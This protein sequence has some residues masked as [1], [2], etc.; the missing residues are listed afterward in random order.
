MQLDL[1]RKLY[2]LVALF[3]IVSA[4]Y[5]LTGRGSLIP[6]W[7]RQIQDVAPVTTTPIPPTQ[8]PT[9]CIPTAYNYKGADQE[10]PKLIEYIR[11][12]LLVSPSVHPYKLAHPERE[13]FSQYN[14]SKIANAMLKGMKGGFFVEVGALDGETDSNSIFFER[15][16][17]W[18]GLLIE[19]RP[20]VFDVLK[21]KNRNAYLIRVALSINT[22]ASDVTF[23]NDIGLGSR[24][25][26]KGIT[27]K[28]MPFFSILRALDVK[29]IDFLS[30]DIESFEVKMLKTVPWD[31][32]KI[33]LM[34]IEVNIIPEGRDYITNFLQGKGYK[35]LGFGYHKIDAW[36][37]LP[38]LLTTDVKPLDFSP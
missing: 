35:F 12:E 26:D 27:V 11:R 19:A 37:A 22:Y 29:I 24:L 23:R 28:G 4:L 32:L 38:E 7:S 8:S 20:S 18:R 10:D 25:A 14:Q 5:Y 9:P 34:C 21:T 3:C 6:D 31:K 1:F 16:L 13:H 15:Q 33:R 17:G 36:Y 30:L 2:M